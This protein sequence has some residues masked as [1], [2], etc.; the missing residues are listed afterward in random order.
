MLNDLFNSFLWSDQRWRDW[1]GV[2]HS[3]ASR[4]PPDV[5]HKVHRHWHQFEVP[6]PL[7]H[8]LLGT[9][10]L[11]IGMAGLT[12]NCLVLWIFGTSRNLRGGTNLLVMNLA[13]ADLLMM[14]SQSPVLVANCYAMT[15]TFGPT[16]CEIYGFCGALFGTVSIVTLALIALDRYHAI[17]N[18]YTGWR[19]SYERA[20]VWAAG[21]WAYSAGWCCPPL[22]GW[23]QYVLEGFLTSCTFDYLTEEPWSRI[24]VFLLF[25]FAYVVPLCVITV[26][27]SLIYFSVSRHDHLLVR[28]NVLTKSTCLTLHRRE[29]QLARVVVISVLFWALAWTPYAVVSLLGALSCRTALTPFST[30]LPA[31]FAKLSTVYNPLIYAVSHPTYRQELV[32]RLPGVCCKLGLVKGEESPCT[33]HSL[34]SNASRCEFLSRTSSVGNIALRSFRKSKPTSYRPNR[35]VVRASSSL[36]RKTDV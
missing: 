16:A 12:G 7:W 17:V 29:T 21:S 32:R 18:P 8:A 31:V 9:I 26:C 27:Y 13:L 35:R 1:E 28:D 14:A 36:P 20:V 6:H 2:N 34:S 30:M 3:L 25:V 11:L 15:W 23:N 5:C 19:L 24:Y 22:L 10:Y 33:H 4:V